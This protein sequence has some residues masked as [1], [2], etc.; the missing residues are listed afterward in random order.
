MRVLVTGGNGFIGRH[1]VSALR[2]RGHRV[3][4]LTRSAAP[5]AV[6]EDVEIV[7][8]DLREDVDLA[9][10]L[11]GVD[12][13]VHCAAAMGGGMA[14]QRA[15][16]VEATRRLLAAMDRAGVR[17]IVGISTFALYDVLAIPAGS[18][19]DEQSAL[20]APAEDGEPYAVTKREQED[21]IRGG[22]VAGDR[23]WTILRPGIVFGPGRTWSYHLGAQLG[24]KRWVAYAGDSLLP[25]TYV[26]NCAEAIAMAV[27]TGAAV[28]A[29]LNVVDSDLPTRR[30]YMEALARR[31]TPQ[32][33]IYD[34][35]WGVLDAA[36][37]VASWVDRTLMFGKAPIPD[38][39]RRSSL[40]V[41]CKPLRYSNDL[42]RAVLGWKPRHDLATAI[43]RS[44]PPCLLS[45]DGSS[46]HG[47]VQ[48]ARPHSS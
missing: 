21:L 12:A 4:I 43:E 42:V 46:R 32:P 33:R 14:E 7:H 23:K 47:A 29:V 13:V 44:L 2:D 41:R 5:S 3:K 34:L 1:V 35:S 38:L 16:T 37:G 19:L 17:R 36:A 31:T 22:S 8:A 25:L 6:G 20:A 15:V 48:S 40:H 45:A 28:G 39:L 30:G 18:V 26:A 10:G 27:D 24:R 9:P 11:A